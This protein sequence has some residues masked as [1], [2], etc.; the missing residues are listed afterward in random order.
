MRKEKIEENISNKSFRDN[1]DIPVINYLDSLDKNTEFTMLEVGSGE[2]RFVKK[3]INKYPNIKITCIEINPQLANIGASLGLTVIN[4][5]IL[6]L[7]ASSQ[8]DI[9][10]CSHVIEH[11]SYP[12]ITKVLE[13]LV[14]SVSKQGRLII[15]S[16][17]MWEHFYDDLDHVRPYPPESIYAYFHATQQQKRGDAKISIDNVWYRT[18]ARHL[19]SIDKRNNIYCISF[20]RKPI[21]RIINSINKQYQR[22]W[23]KYRWP[24]SD[25]TGYVAIIRRLDTLANDV[26]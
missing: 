11:F 15:R 3:I 13:F 8:Y 5:N 17:L 22:L 20:L 12:D 2:C 7:T 16:P 6:N 4:E 14:S 18:Q 24:A 19:S 10:H 26:C 9:V 25:P 1:E 23:D 21:N